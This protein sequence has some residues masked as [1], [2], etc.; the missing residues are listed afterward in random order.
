MSDEFN[1]LRPN[2]VSFDLSEVWDDDDECSAML[3]RILHLKEKYDQLVERNHS[4]KIS[5][6]EAKHQALIVELREQEQQENQLLMEQTKLGDERDKVEQSMSETFLALKAVR[7]EK[8]EGKYALPSDIE[9]YGKNLES[10][11]KKH[12]QATDEQTD[13][14]HRVADWRERMTERIK[15]IRGLRDEID[16]VWTHMQRSRGIPTRHV[17]RETG[18]I[19]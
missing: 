11:E 16:N 3:S 18:L 5:A 19:A 4:A 8:P 17:D 10:A 13:Y 14:N 12:Q 9:A 6:L 15:A 7:D 2:I 1:T